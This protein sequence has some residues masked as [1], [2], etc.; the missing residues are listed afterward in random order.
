MFLRDDMRNAY[1]E[2]FH[3]TPEEARKMT[4]HDAYDYADSVYSLRF[5][6]YEKHWHWTPL[7][8][9]KIETTQI[10]CLLLPCPGQMRKLVISKLLE[11]P[12]LDI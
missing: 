3:L 2:Y 8:I 4:Y 12:L 1:K 11:K 9:Y 10:Y 5:H 7:E 6:G